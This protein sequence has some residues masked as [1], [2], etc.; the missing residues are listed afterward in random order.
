M[1]PKQPSNVTTTSK[2]ELTPEQKELLGLAM[3]FARDFAANPPT[4]PG[5]TVQPFDP[6]Q[7]KGQEM[8]LG[9]VGQQQGTAN[10]ATS[11][12]GNLAGGSALRP[13]TGTQQTAEQKLLTGAYG[14]PTGGQ[15]SPL[16]TSATNPAN[17]NALSSLLTGNAG[18]WNN[19]SGL[20]TQLAAGPNYQR[21]DVQAQEKLLQGGPQSSVRN[22][23][24]A[25]AQG[26]DLTAAN[27]GTNKLLAG[28]AGGPN[29]TSSII[30]QL[31]GMGQAGGPM[32]Q[33]AQGSDFREM[34]GAGAGAQ[35]ALLNPDLLNADANPHL[36]GY[37]S[38][39]TRPIEQD[40]MESVLPQLRSSAA[41]TGNFGSSRAQLGYGLATGRAAQAIGDTSSRIASESYGQGLNALN[42]AFSTESGRQNDVRSAML[43]ALGLKSA[44][45]GTA[46]NLSEAQAGRVQTGVGQG[47][48]SALA[49]EGLRQRGLESAGALEQGAV[50]SSQAAI[51][52]GLGAGT[53]RAALTQRGLESAGALQE[54]QAQRIQSGRLAG[55]QVE[56]GD[57]QMAINQMLQMLG[58]DQGNRQ[59]AQQGANA[60]LDRGTQ[61]DSTNVSAQLGAL[62][63]TGGVQSAQ[64]TPALTTS[65]VG[66]VRQQQ[67]Q[68]GLTAQQQAEYRQKLLPLLMAQEL[69][70]LATGQPGGTTINTGPGA[71]QPSLGQK[72]LGGVASGAGLSTAMGPLGWLLGLGSAFL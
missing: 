53:D 69:G 17:V 48:E 29:N 7:T 27:S 20:A 22:F 56:Q 34:Q 36:Q 65:G 42:Q 25:L 28:T 19:S 26:P 15:A 39:A 18:G 41:G 49:G 60:S 47:V 57:R 33:L 6:Q 51:Q 43:A 2:T 37:I 31:L 1:G 16:P 55:L 61:R 8:A 14:Q 30:S 32:S 12:Y 70:G 63:Q 9:A 71:Q 4:M 68:A 3:P 5:N 35:A 24:G 38:A 52:A 11:A 67:G 10:Q 13:Q 66:D 40:L 58:I 46:G 59:L 64:T 54:N 45:L 72:L 23:A 62:G 21:G 44:N 50:N